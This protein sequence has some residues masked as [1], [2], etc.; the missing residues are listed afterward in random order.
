MKPLEFA[1]AELINIMDEALNIS[2]LFKTGK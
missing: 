1:P 2:T